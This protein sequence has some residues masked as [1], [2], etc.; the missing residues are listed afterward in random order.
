MGSFNTFGRTVKSYGGG[1]MV[2]HSV[3]HK[4]PVGGVISNLADFAEGTVIP[5]GSMAIFNTANATVEIVTD[6]AAS[7]I[8]DV[9]GL[10]ENDVYVD[11]AAKSETGAATATVVYGGVIYSSRLAVEVPEAVWKNLPMVKQFK[12]A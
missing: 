11:E 1:K 10:L 6:P 4:F 7:N 5:A 2:W 9:N 12:E 3:D 8:G